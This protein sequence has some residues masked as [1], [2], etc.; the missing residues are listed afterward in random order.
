MQFKCENSSISR[1][2][3]Y[4]KYAVEMKYDTIKSIHVCLCVSVCVCIYIYIY[5]YMDVCVGLCVLWMTGGIISSIF[6]VVPECL[7]DLPLSI[8]T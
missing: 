6:E 1:N 4:H 8:L 3:V 5:I 2:S 7:E